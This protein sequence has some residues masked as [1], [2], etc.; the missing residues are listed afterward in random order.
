MN[1]KLL[2]AVLAAGALVLAACGGEG[3]ENGARGDARGNGIDRGFVAEMVPHHQSAVEM[4]KIAQR[5]GESAFVK[6]LADDIVTSQSTEIRTLRREDEALDVA[7]IKRE[8]LPMPAGMMGMD[9]DPKALEGADPFDRAFIEMMIP[10]H[11]GAI[12]MAKV[13]LAKGEDPELK[14]LAQDV[15]D[16]QTR[17]IQAMERRLEAGG[18]ASADDS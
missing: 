18:S 5:R 3:E 7:G 10:H 15:V 14:A 9:D 16:A 6:K 11:K 2:P 17:E 1:R 13:E 4:A 12:E 8:R